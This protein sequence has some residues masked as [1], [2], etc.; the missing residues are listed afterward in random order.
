MRLLCFA[1]SDG[2]AAAST[3]QRV[4]GLIDVAKAAGWDTELV[5]VP[6]LPWW[7]IFPRRW[8]GFFRYWAILSRIQPDTVVLLQRT[9]RRPEFLWLLRR[10]RSCISYIVSDFD[11]AVWTHSPVHTAELIRLSDEVW[12][13]SKMILDYC[14][15]RHANAK[16]VPTT[17]DMARFSLPKQE[18]QPPVIG[19]VGDIHAHIRNLRSFSAILKSIHALLPPFQLRLIGV[20]AYEHEIRTMFSFLGTRLSVVGWVKPM[21]IP[22]QIAHFSIGIM[23]LN[24]NEFNKGK[25]ALKLIEYLAAGVPVVAS[26]VGENRF[27]VEMPKHGYIASGMEEWKTALFSLLSDASVRNG[28]GQRGQEFVRTQYDR[29]YVYGRLLSE[30]QSHAA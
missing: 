29:T 13:G 12:C 25:S 3:R 17:V 30:L 22:S 18:E 19:W 7:N 5:V 6:A 9:L 21:D 20:T 23:P 24:A 27:V 8:I 10:Y 28:A 4:L 14:S 26:D 1:K 15:A 16:F 2:V 11:D